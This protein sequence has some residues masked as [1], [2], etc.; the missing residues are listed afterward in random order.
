MVCEEDEVDKAS[1]FDECLLW[2]Q[3]YTESVLVQ[4]FEAFDLLLVGG[5]K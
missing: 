5:G 4:G 3:V 1:G 2:L